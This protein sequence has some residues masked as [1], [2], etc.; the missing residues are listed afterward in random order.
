MN[1]QKMLKSVGIKCDMNALGGYGVTA[2]AAG[3][4]VYKKSYIH[5]ALLAGVAL[6]LYA[7]L[8]DCTVSLI[9]GSFVALVATLY[10]RPAAEGF[11]D[12]PEEEDEDVK[13]GLEE[14]APKKKVKKVKKATAS[15]P[16]PDNG[17]RGEFFQVG[18]KYKMPS[19]QDDAEFHL[20]AGTTFM[21]AFKSLKPDQISAMTKDTQELMQTQKQLM[22]TLSTLKPLIQDGKEMM[23]MFQSYFGEGTASMA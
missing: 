16:P 2:A 22:S 7:I 6:A 23:G 21:N 9:A 17:E 8:Q 10:A 4:I 14:D 5:L 1:V 11:S 20:D 18:K 19:E 12:M 3:F 15:A 13:E